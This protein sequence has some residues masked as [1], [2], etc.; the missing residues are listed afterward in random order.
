MD[1]ISRSVPASAFKQAWSFSRHGHLQV[2]V[3]EFIGH[4]PAARAAD[5]AQLEKVRLDHINQR[6]D[7]F[8]ER[9]RHR[10]DAHRSSLVKADHCGKKI[11][12]KIVE[13]LLIHTFKLE[14]LARHVGSD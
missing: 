11:P 4:A 12:I 2:S 8:V 3:S 13:T 5:E 6:I 10:L 9:R 1:L 14:G 7:L